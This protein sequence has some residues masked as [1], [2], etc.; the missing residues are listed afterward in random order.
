MYV[1]Q[2]IR[3][4]NCIVHGASEGFTS[5][6]EDVDSLVYGC[7]VYGCGWKAPDRGHGHCVYTQNK[8]PNKTYSN[9]IFS[10]R[11][12]DGQ[13]TMQ[14]YGTGNT[15]LDHFYI[16]DNIFMDQGQFLLGGG[17]TFHDAHVN[18]NVF[19]TTPVWIGYSLNKARVNGDA[20]VTKNLVV[21]ADIHFW[22]IEALEEANNTIIGGKKLIYAPHSPDAI[23]TPGGS[24]PAAPTILVKPNAF[25]PGRG[26]LVIFNW[27]S[28]SKPKVT[29]NFK[30]LVGAK[31]PFRLMDPK[32]FYGAPVAQGT[33]DAQGCAAVNAPNKFNVYVVLSGPAKETR[34][35]KATAPATRQATSR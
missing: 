25:E 3:I 24:P 21:D 34:P 32:D 30:G 23:V 1:G 8:D 2:G 27:Q 7:I 17:A 6:I 9:C 4:I 29:V 15:F 10:T 12:P 19:D 28:D 5:E 22:W 33:T 26:N 13:Q 14:A 31:R 16:E 35:A 18:G 11:Y 20:V